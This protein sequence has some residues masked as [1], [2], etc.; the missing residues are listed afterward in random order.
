[1]KRKVNLAEIVRYLAGFGVA[2]GLNIAV[3]LIGVEAGMAGSPLI[4]LAGCGVYSLTFY[5]I[6]RHFVFV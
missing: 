4:H 1:M 6:S 2:W 3:V 5:A